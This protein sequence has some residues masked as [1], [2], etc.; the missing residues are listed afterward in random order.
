MNI[1]SF[2]WHDGRTQYMSA[3][4]NALSVG[5]LRAQAVTRLSMFQRAHNATCMCFKL[6]GDRLVGIQEDAGGR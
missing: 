1:V 6:P 2:K 4:W 3:G 5:I